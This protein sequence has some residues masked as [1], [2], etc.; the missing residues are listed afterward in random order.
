LGNQTFVDINPEQFSWPLLNVGVTTLGS[1]IPVI[2]QVLDSGWLRINKTNNEIFYSISGDFIRQLKITIPKG[3]SGISS[4]IE[5]TDSNIENLLSSIHPELVIIE[6]QTGKFYPSG[7]INTLVNWQITSGY[8]IKVTDSVELTINGTVSQNRSLQLKPGWNLIPVLS[9]CNVNI[10]QL[11]EG[12]NPVIIKEVASFNVCW[13][14]MNITSLQFL[15][16][17]KSYLVLMNSNEEIE[18]PV[19]ENQESLFQR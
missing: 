14:Q 16:P 1:Q 12:K 19:C 7:N 5:P 10:A 2:P 8:Q 4:T 15:S 18:F 17:G 3:W 11:F 6:N 9:S 13:P